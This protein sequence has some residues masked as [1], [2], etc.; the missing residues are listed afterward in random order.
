MNRRDFL[1]GM[2][3]ASI[4]IT[5]PAIV[6]SKGIRTFYA[7]HSRIPKND[8]RDWY[9]YEIFDISTGRVSCTETRFNQQLGRIYRHGFA[10]GE[11]SV[12]MAMR[13]IRHESDRSIFLIDSLRQG[14]ETI[15]I[16]TL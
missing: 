6:T 16:I 2:A 3:V 15:E 10:K 5:A 4:A 9:T 13:A 8:F 11:I 1:K 14:I 7:P 12:I